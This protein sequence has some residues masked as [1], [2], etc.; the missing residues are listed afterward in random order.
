MDSNT[1]AYMKSSPLVSMYVT[2]YNQEKWVAEALKGALAQDYENLQL[3]F[4]DDCSVDGTWEIMQRIAAEYKGPHKIVLNRNP[5]NRGTGGHVN[6]LI[7]LCDSDIIIASHADDISL[8]N[9]VSSLVKVFMENPSAMVVWSNFDIIDPD[10]NFLA[11]GKQSSRNLPTLENVSRGKYALT[12][13]AMAFRKLLFKEFGLM[14]P[15]CFYEDLIISFR[16]ILLGE[17]VKIEEPLVLYR[18]SD[19]SLT[20]HYSAEKYSPAALKHLQKGL[21]LDVNYRVM[22]LT[23]SYI[24]ERKHPELAWELERIRRNIYKVIAKNYLTYITFAFSAGMALKIYLRFYLFT[25]RLKYIR[26]AFVQKR[27]SLSKR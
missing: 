1:G 23:D 2:S 13:C 17:I 24:Y 9:R 21:C 8:P 3:I 6:K 22:W 15:R 27:K 19:L 7:E 25:V 12:G 14:D 18:S 4:S 11:H 16:G 26:K 5:I 20:N 10:G